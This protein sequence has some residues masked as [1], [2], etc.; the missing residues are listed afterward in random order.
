MHEPIKRKLL[1]FNHVPY[2][3]KWL[4]KTN[5][6][7]SE[8]GNKYVKNKTNEKLKSCTTSNFDWTPD[9]RIEKITLTLIWACFV[10]F[11]LY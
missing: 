4:R 1:R 5:M 11:Q 3:T 8:L 9:I 6:K 10:R 7:R 2:I